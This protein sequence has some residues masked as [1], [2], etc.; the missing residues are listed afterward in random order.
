MLID[1]KKNT[2]FDRKEQCIEKQKSSFLLFQYIS[3]RIQ[4]EHPEYKEKAIK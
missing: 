1:V 3:Q 2:N 4:D